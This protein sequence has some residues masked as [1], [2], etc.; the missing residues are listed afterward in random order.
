M[1]LTVLGRPLNP[2]TLIEEADHIYTASSQL[3][4]EALMANRKVSCFGAPFYSGW[5]LTD[6]RLT[7]ARRT[8][9]RSSKR[10]LPPPI[11][12]T[13]AYFDPWTRKPVEP[14]A[15][16]DALKFLRDRFCRETRGRS[17]SIVLPA[18]KRRPLAALLAG[19]THPP[20]FT[21]S[22]GEAERT[23]KQHGGVIAAWGRG[24][25]L[26]S[27]RERSRAVPVLSIEDGFIRSSGLGAA[28]TPS[29][30]YTIDEAGIYYDPARPSDLEKPLILDRP[31]P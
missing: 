5:G 26:I 9:R 31:H 27:S 3:G 22:Y 24:A 15:A 2:W 21:A 12:V 29:L 1:S 28:F 13:R 18:G 20:V 16:V 30:S 14:L 11:S 19:P 8:R 10:S 23:A 25:N 17:Y 4:L 7:I 6:D